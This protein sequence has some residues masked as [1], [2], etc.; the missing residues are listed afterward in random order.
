MTK[1]IK[2]IQWTAENKG[3]FTL[4]ARHSKLGKASNANPRNFVEFVASYRNC[5]LRSMTDFFRRYLLSG[6]FKDHDVTNI[7][8]LSEDSCLFSTSG[9]KTETLDIIQSYLDILGTG[10]R[11]PA[12]WAYLDDEEKSIV[13]FV[14]NKGFYAELYCLSD[15]NFSV[16]HLLETGKETYA[17]VPVIFTTEFPDDVVANTLA[18]G[19]CHLHDY[20]PRERFDLLSKGGRKHSGF[21]LPGKV[22]IMPVRTNAG[23]DGWDTL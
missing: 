23:V 15:E 22:N 21:Q 11:I 9:S 10:G 20:L 1:I 2:T 17:F 8:T 4:C 13:H 6:R 19:S 14:N 3:V 18:T 7:A 12:L 5:D 16:V